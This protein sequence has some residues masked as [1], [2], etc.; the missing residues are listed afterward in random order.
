LKPDEVLRKLNDLV[1]AAELEALTALAAALSSAA[2][3]RLRPLL[4]L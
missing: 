2:S 1:A 4:T 3:A